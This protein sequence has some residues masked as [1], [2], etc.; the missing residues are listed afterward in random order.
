[1]VVSK[2]KKEALVTFVTVH[3]RPNYHSL[4]VRLQGLNPN[5]DYRLEG[6]MENECV[7]GHESNQCL[8]F[9]FGYYHITIVEMIFPVR[10]DTVIIPLPYQIVILVI[11]SCLLWNLFLLFLCNLCDI[12]LITKG[13]CQ[14]NFPSCLKRGISAHCMIRAVRNVCS[15]DTDAIE[16][17][18]IQEGTALIYPLS[19]M[20]AHNG[21]L[22][23][24]GGLPEAQG[25]PDR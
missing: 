16:R 8:F 22:T 3:A 15:D 21:G 12:Q 9:I 11:H 24:P 18:G 2:D 13:S 25:F 4:K 10:S 5:L 1:M 23:P 14:G 7:Y 20:G 6:E 17:L 19:A